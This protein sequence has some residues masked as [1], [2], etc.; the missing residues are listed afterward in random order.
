MFSKSGLSPPPPHARHGQNPTP[1]RFC[2]RFFR[3]YQWHRCTMQLHRA[4]QPA[5]RA[6][7]APTASPPSLPL[8]GP[9][10]RSG[11]STTA[12]S[13]K[14]TMT[15]A[16]CAQTRQS[17]S[18]MHVGDESRPVMAGDRTVA[19]RC[20]TPRPFFLCFN[21]SR[22][23]ALGCAGSPPG[24][25]DAKGRPTRMVAA[26]PIPLQGQAG[27]VDGGRPVPP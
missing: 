8:F 5:T 7:C 17:E 13:P 27:G 10:R 18:P 11:T 12:R 20:R 19:L 25:N 14:C 16:M 6:V 23:S 15:V 22:K 21:T 2:A 26:Q 3:L 24:P 1:C 9:A 4:C